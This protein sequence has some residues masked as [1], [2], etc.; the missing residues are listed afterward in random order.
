MGVLTFKSFLSHLERELRE[1]TRPE[2]PPR[3]VDVTDYL[4]EQLTSIKREIS[5][6]LEHAEEQNEKQTLQY[7]EDYLID[8][9]SLLYSAGSPHE[10]WRRWA[11]LVSFG[12][13]LLNKHYSAAIYAALAGEWT[14][15]SL[16]PTT[17]TEDADLQTEVIWHLLGKSPSVPEVEDQDDPEARAWLRLARSIPQA[18]HKQTEAALKAISRFWMEELGDT[19][20]HYEVD[21]YPAFHAPACAAAAIARHHGYTPMKLPPASYRFLEPGLAAGDPRP[22]IPSE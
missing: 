7:L 15:I 13:G 5:E 14:A 2:G 17:T 21:A 19:W 22:L 1:L 8:L 16:M 12:Q 9:M 11:A 18:D 10:V 4:D 6:L 3:R 20:D